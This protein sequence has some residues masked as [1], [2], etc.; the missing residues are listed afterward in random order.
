MKIIAS[1]V[2][3]LVSLQLACEVSAGGRV[4]PWF[5]RTFLIALFC[6]FLAS[7]NLS[8]PR[9]LLGCA[10]SDVIILIQ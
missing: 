6:L 5:V 9:F 10:S 8:N 1:V 2:L 7:I 4:M 3:L